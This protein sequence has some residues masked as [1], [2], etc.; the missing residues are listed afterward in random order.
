MTATQSAGPTV[1]ATG[2]R[3]RMRAAV[4]AAHGG[5]GA[6]TVARLTN[7]PEVDAQSAVSLTAMIVTAR[8]TGPGLADVVTLM[9]RL[10][11]TTAATSF[12]GCRTAVLV[13]EAVM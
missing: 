10:P 5:S 8:T 9:A 4:V 6:T 3:D 2:I 12:T 13:S 11:R 7:L 1:H